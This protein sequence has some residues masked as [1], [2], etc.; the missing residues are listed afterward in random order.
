MKEY[1]INARK[2]V[3]G[4]FTIRKTANGEKR[5][6][7]DYL[8]LKC[9]DSNRWAIVKP[10]DDMARVSATATGRDF[11]LTR[12]SAAESAKSMIAQWAVAKGA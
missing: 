3:V 11:H 9:T 10:I 12:K 1:Q 8:I 7:G 2:W 6:D 5:F 4:N